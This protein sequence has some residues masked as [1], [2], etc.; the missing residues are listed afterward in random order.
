MQRRTLRIALDFFRLGAA[1]P[2][3]L[4]LLW[5]MFFEHARVGVQDRFLDLAFVLWPTGIQ[6]LVL[7]H[8]ESSFGHVLTIA[9]LVIENAI[10]YSVVALAVHWIVARVRHV[11]LRHSH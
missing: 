8:P 4:L 7:P 3:V 11:H 6:I 5:R 9:I 1:I 2:L 10:L